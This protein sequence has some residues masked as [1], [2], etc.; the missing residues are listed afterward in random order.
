MYRNLAWLALG[1]F[2]IGTEGFMIGG[3]LPGMAK[4]LGVS[5]SAAG[6]L[7]TMF[8][9]AYAAGTPLIAVA[10]ARVPRKTLLLTAMAVFAAANLLAAWAPNYFV[11][12]FARILLALSAGTF[13]PAS[14]GYASMAIAPERRGRA[15]SFIYSGMTIALVIGVPFGTLLAAHFDWRSTFEAVALIS[16]VALIGIWLKLEPVPAPPAVGL[17]ERISVA[18]RPDVLAVLALTVLS[19]AGAFAVATYLGTYFETIFDVAPRN[20]AYIYLVFG[21]A[22]AVGNGWGGYAADRWN[23]RRFIAAAT[24]AMAFAF[25]M[26]SALAMFPSS[27]GS[28]WAAIGC[29]VLWGVSGWA[30]PSLQ[31]VRLVQIDPKLA[32]VTLSLN[33]SATYV[34]GALGAGIGAAAIEFTSVTSIGVVGAFFALAAL[35]LLLGTSKENGLANGPQGGIDRART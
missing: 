1:A 30:L 19:L 27:R 32:P 34:G 3:I 17:S 5:V 7:V 15:L 33:S 11:L 24:T 28:F 26:L 23:R 29:V 10:T 31:Q 2:A 22:A 16:A 12:A 9:L 6:H 8:A 18:R 21:L 35:A 25:A 14:A 13:M 20:V 4:D